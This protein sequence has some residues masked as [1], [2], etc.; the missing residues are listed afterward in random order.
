M[1]LDLILAGMEDDA[2]V[3][4]SPRTDDLVELDRA[5]D[6]SDYGLETESTVP[7]LTKDKHARPSRTVRECKTKAELDDLDRLM[8][9]SVGR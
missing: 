6:S 2:Q 4:Q 1:N 7:T 3:P 5:F 8:L 9:K